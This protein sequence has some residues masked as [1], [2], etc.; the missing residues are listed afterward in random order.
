MMRP[1]SKFLP[2]FLAL[3]GFL[4]T[5]E[6]AAGASIL[7]KF[8]IFAL[9]LEEGVSFLITKNPSGNASATLDE[10]EEL[11]RRKQASLIDEISLRGESGSRVEAKSQGH[12]IS[13]EA[14]LSKDQSVVGIFSSILAEKTQLTGQQSVAFGNALFNGAVKSSDGQSLILVYVLPFLE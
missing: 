12:T 2:I 8:Q 14:V 4:S 13:V 3:A 7:L 1:A 9:P 11:V 5:L 6:A 10:I